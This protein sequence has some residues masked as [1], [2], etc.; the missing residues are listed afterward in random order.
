MYSKDQDIPAL[1]A[2]A[3]S[4][5][6]RG[7]DGDLNFLCKRDMSIHANELINEDNTNR[8]HC[9]VDLRTVVIL[10]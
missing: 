4:I 2:G 3:A 9:C 10:G 8:L 7:R 6:A 1:A 5:V